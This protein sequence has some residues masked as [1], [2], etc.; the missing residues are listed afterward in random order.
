MSVCVFLTRLEKY[1]V[2]SKFFDCQLKLLLRED[3]KQIEKYVLQIKHCMAFYGI[4]INRNISTFRKVKNLKIS[5]NVHIHLL[6]NI[7][8][9]IIVFFILA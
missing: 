9:I 2:S 3:E 5:K 8:N 4:S 6:Y 7:Y 1:F